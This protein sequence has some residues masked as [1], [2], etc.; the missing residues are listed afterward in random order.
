[1]GNCRLVLPAVALAL[2]QLVE[3]PHTTLE[4]GHQLVEDAATSHGENG[5]CFKA[6][7][8]LP[9][10]I[11]FEDFSHKEHKHNVFETELFKVF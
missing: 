9:K 4:A 7:V 5:Q 2:V 3:V 6:F 1:M 11:I 8:I 10:H